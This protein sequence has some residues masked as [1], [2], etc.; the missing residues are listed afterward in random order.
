MVLNAS[1]DGLAISM[2][3][4][5]GDEAYSNLQVRMNG[6]PQPIEV[7]GRMA[8]TTK[9]KKRAGIQLVDVSEEQHGKIR[10]WLAQEGVRDVN[11]LPRISETSTSV[12]PAVADT[13]IASKLAEE[14]RPNLSPI[15]A[16]GGTIPSALPLTPTAFTPATN[17]QVLSEPHA[18]LLVG[19]KGT[20]PEFLAPA[21]D[22]PADQPSFTEGT[23]SETKPS[24]NTGPVFPRFRG[25]EW[26]LASITMVPRRRSK[27]EGLSALGLLLLWIAIPS[28]GI[29]LIVGRRPLEQWLSRATARKN[30]SHF[31][32]PGPEVVTASNESPDTSNADMDATSPQSIPARTVET[33]AA[34]KSFVSTPPFINTG[35]LNS[36]STQ[37]RR[38]LKPPVSPASPESANARQVSNVDSST[39]SNSAAKDD[40]KEKST[41]PAIAHDH[42]S[43]A[44]DN[45][46]PRT[47]GFSKP[48]FND[49]AASTVAV[50][51]RGNAGTTSSHLP[52]S[53]VTLTGSHA[54]STVTVTPGHAPENS[55][56]HQNAA[57]STPS[58]QAVGTPPA[59]W[60]Q[61]PN[62]SATSTP[63]T[64]GNSAATSASN[65]DAVLTAS[66]TQASVS[67]STSSAKPSD[68]AP[69][70]SDSSSVS[71]RAPNVSPNVGAAA[72]VDAATRVA[73]GTY[74]SSSSRSAA[75]TAPVNVAP[76]NAQSPLHGVMLVARK[77]NQSFLLK[78]PVES[79]SG[80]RALSVAIQRF[81]MVPPESRWHHHGP[82]A[83]LAI[84]ELLTQV[85][86]LETAS[87]ARPGD[88]IT[89]RAYVDKNGSV[90]DLKPISGRFALMPRVMHDLREW[91]FDQTLIDGKPVESEINITVEFRSGP[92]PS[93]S[94]GRQIQAQN[95]IRP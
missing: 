12:L 45:K 2:A 26:D 51:S 9:S 61:S 54:A 80:G 72:P 5:V 15:A 78:L 40:S 83:K 28:F 79:V 18:S 48:N 41:A 32:A 33:P 53:A 63:G 4:P 10:E 27:P 47:G 76:V 86:T 59:S 50:N 34:T 16:T 37:E 1:D 46:V 43:I 73:P 74:G 8:W 22:E 87:A 52:V 58:I 7:Y 44:I 57:G 25:N 93:A 70:E 84:G 49:H 20:E 6:L 65:G 88:S 64:S 60:S 11:L 69:I 42:Q 14:Q 90:Q 39:N 68:S 77:N 31:S 95:S 94:R 3:I 19:L 23:V 56:A 85:T 89:V 35:L 62:R 30:I 38:A 21:E 92:Q 81:V 71:G 24:Q 29:G 13:A 91:Q 82:I 55:I 36:M 67:S 66:K 17:P 75:P